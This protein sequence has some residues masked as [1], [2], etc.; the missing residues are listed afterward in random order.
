MREFVE[1]R[2]QSWVADGERF[3][4]GTSVRVQLGEE[5]VAGLQGGG[6]SFAGRV[7]PAE[8]D[9]SD[10]GVERGG[11][12][13][14]V[15]AGVAHESTFHEGCGSLVTVP[16]RAEHN[17]NYV[18]ISAILAAPSDRNAISPKPG[19]VPPGATKIGAWSFG[20]GIP[21]VGVALQE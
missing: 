4:L 21:G 1:E 7:G 17:V 3:Q 13:E 5:R 15:T 20:L 8:P 14:P 11:R 2:P 9:T 6:D 16:R 19:P 12:V 18:P 10:Q